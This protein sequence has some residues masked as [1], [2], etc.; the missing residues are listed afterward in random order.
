M[1]LRIFAVELYVWRS[2]SNQAGVVIPV[3]DGQTPR[4]AAELYKTRFSDSRELQALLQRSVGPAF[5]GGTFERLNDADFN[6]RVLL[7]ANMPGD[8][9]A[10]SPRV[11]PFVEPLAA[12]HVH[13]YILPVAADLGI[14]RST[15][16]LIRLLDRRFPSFIAIGGDDTDRTLFD[17]SNH[18][19]I[20][21]NFRRDK[22][23]A[24]LLMQKIKTIQ[25]QSESINRIF[26]VCRGAQLVASLMGH[27]FGVD[28]ATDLPTSKVVHGIPA[29]NGPAYT[30]GG[31]EP[32]HAIQLTGQAGGILSTL[33]E[34]ERNFTGNTYH[35]Q[36]I[37]PSPQAWMPLRTTAIS[38]DD[39]VV[40]AAEYADSVLLLQFHPELM[41][42]RSSGEVRLTGERI[43]SG[44]A[45]FLTPRH[46]FNCENQLRSGT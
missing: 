2:A 18:M 15:G 34:G 42:I 13:S 3:V 27:S 5:E 41:R 28:I 35:H 37:L 21:T 45:G 1:P 39:G 16:E 32:T 26:A 14:E 22:F 25:K 40:E 30:G 20:N 7:I 29:G 6:E 10:G 36:H 43:M 9:E 11:A 38:P 8:A 44:S 33:L 17:Q 12:K 46:T 4:Q 23:E 19:S 31:P 24:A